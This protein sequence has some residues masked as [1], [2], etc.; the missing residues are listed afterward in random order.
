MNIRSIDRDSGLTC[1]NIDT[2]T[3][4]VVTLNHK[5]SSFIVHTG[6]GVGRNIGSMYMDSTRALAI[7][8]GNRRGTSND[9]HICPRHQRQR[10]TAAQL[11]FSCGA[12]KGGAGHHQ[13]VVTGLQVYII[14]CRYVYITAGHPDLRPAAVLYYNATIRS[15]CYNTGQ[16]YLGLLVF[17]LQY[18]SCRELLMRLYVLYRNI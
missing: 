2:A 10:R 11:H 8:I 15:L 1:I 14:S 16:L 12:C 7:C 18:T 9:I 4:S 17:I 13:H 3:F 5:G 6:S